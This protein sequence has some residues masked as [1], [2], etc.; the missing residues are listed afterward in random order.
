MSE[1]LD[2]TV[3]METEGLIH[4]YSSIDGYKE[5][6]HRMITELSRTEPEESGQSSNHSSS[7]G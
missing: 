1:S 6:I 3:S 4:E 7:G 5:S 2:I